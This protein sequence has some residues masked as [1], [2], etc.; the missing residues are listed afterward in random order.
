LSVSICI[1]AYNEEKYIADTIKSVLSQTIKPNEII[2]VDDASTDK[3]SQIV[4]K[5]PIRYYRN[6]RNMGIGYTRTKCVE[7]VNS[8]YIG[9]ISGDD[10]LIPEFIETMLKYSKKYSNTI[11]Y[12][13]YYRCNEE[14][15]P[16]SIYKCRRV[17]DD[18][19]LDIC[20]HLARR[21]DMFV[22]YNL[23]GPT[24]LFKQCN[25]DPNTKYGEDLEHLMRALLVYKIKFKLVP[26]PLFKYRVHKSANTETHYWDVI[27]TNR[28]NFDKINKILNKKVLWD[29]IFKEIPKRS[30]RS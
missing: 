28:K 5:Y 22:C 9:F 27:R 14:G 23:F 17:P 18:H 1:P 12:S 20:I 13:D 29:N 25:F 6:I 4:R 2:V 11:F 26:K 19:F 30:N 24:K 10:M 8:D 7:L 3:T 16:T 21:H 15:I